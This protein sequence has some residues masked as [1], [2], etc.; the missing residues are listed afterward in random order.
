M[1]SWFNEG[2]LNMKKRNLVWTAIVFTA[3]VLA[4]RHYSALKGACGHKQAKAVSAADDS[5]QP[6]YIRETKT[7]GEGL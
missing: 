7:H 6:V 1:P 5:K 3:G 2:G 4:G